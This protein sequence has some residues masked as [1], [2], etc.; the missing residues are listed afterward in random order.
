MTLLLL[1]GTGESRRIATALAARGT[2]CL[3]WPD[4]AARLPGD[5]PLPI[6]AGTV[7]DCIAQPGIS[8]VLDATHPFASDISQAAAQA[9]AEKG[10]PYCL[11]LRPEWQLQPGDRWT[12]IA[13]EADA[14]A[15]IAAGSTVFLATGRDGLAHFAGLKECYIYCRQIGSTDAP[16]PLPNGEYLIQHPPFSVE[17]EVALFRRLGI[18]WLVLRNA[19]ST[20]ADTKLTAARQLGLRV[21][22]IARPA[23]PPD[24]PIVTTTEEALAWVKHYE[25]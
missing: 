14:P 3:L 25:R 6:C 16:Y 15:H 4:P 7:P 11:L 13:S 5:W 2:D 10:L 21:L 9:A 12:Q 20:R 18:D 1:A 17:A 22:V 8:A 19:G 24:V 23:P